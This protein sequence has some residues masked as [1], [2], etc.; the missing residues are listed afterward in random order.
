MIILKNFDLL[1][2]TVCVVGQ[3]RKKLRNKGE[4]V[5]N[6]HRY[7]FLNTTFESFG[8]FGFLNSS[9]F[10]T[11]PGIGTRGWMEFLLYSATFLL[12]LFCWI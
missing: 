9:G 11:S 5:Y 1:F 12:V 3:Q 8:Y 6:S 4:I 10:R 2:G 7:I